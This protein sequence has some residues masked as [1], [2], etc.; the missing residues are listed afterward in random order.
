M[1]KDQLHSRIKMFSGPLSSDGTLSPD[2]RNQV[3]AFGS[4]DGVCA[5][6]IGVEFVEARNLAL[7]SL[8]YTEE[9]GHPVRLPA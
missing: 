4:K 7:V 2:L 3:A 6:S 5:R 1:S 9:P 8:G